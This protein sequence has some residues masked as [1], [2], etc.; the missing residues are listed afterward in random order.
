[1]NYEFP[2]INHIDQVLPA[3]AEF[4]EFIVADKGEYKVINY[5]VTTEDTFPPIKSAGGSASQ[6]REREK[7]NKI[8]RECRGLIFSAAS[9]ALIARRY[10]KFFNLN[11]RDETR[12]ENIDWNKPHKILEKLDGSMVTP[13]IQ[14]ETGWRWGTKMGITDTSMEAEAFVAVNKQY[15]A[16]ADFAW[17]NFYTPI[18]EW[19][20][21]KNRIV[22]D[23][24][25]DNLVLTAMRE[26]N[27]GE[28]MPY[29]EM[30][31]HAS[32]MN[33]P[34][35]QAFDTGNKTI[36]YIE[37]IVRKSE[38]SEGIVVR[39]DDGHMVKVKSAWYLKLHRCK[40]AI[41]TERGIIA[42]WLGL[43]LDDVISFLDQTE[44]QRINQFIANWQA[45]I[46][47]SASLLEISLQ[48]Y[49]KNKI[50]RKDFALNHA[51]NW[52]NLAKQICFRLWGETYFEIPESPDLLHDEIVNMTTEVMKRVT[53][54]EANWQEFK[55]NFAATPSLDGN[56]GL[57]EE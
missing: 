27:T 23:Y 35:V 21:R 47:R 14:S 42:L 19:C 30:V 3:I 52:S 45:L 1:M 37:E 41:S 44:Q 26:I 57:P 39:F 53:N 15:D 18:F 29:H 48:N 28:Y 33:I 24:P 51:P 8:L 9:G 56:M 17:V 36:D 46:N 50:T 54:R 55:L 16:F 20:S 31:Y 7:R 13:V 6:R 5:V 40:D 10:H 22:L 38:D 32:K 2:I 34:V 11:E 49:A 25:V 43:G 12:S 4:K